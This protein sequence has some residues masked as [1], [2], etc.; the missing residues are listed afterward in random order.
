MSN[1]AKLLSR[2]GALVQQGDLVSARTQLEKAARDHKGS[3]EPWISLAAVHGMGGNY[4][5]ALRCARKAVK[6]A[7]GSL[8]GW[9]NLANAAQSCGEF[10]Q[11]A[12]AF[13][14]AR[15][16][17]GCPPDITLNLGLALAELE[18]WGKAEEALHAYCSRYPG[19]REATLTRGKALA[20]QGEFQAAITI[21]GTYSS[22]HPEDIPALTQLGLLQLQSGQVEDARRNCGQAMESAPDNTDTL[23]LKAALLK[24]EGRYEEARETY[25]QLLRIQQPTPGPQLYILASQACR[26]AGDTD[27]AIAYTRTALELNPHNIPALTTLS[28][29]MLRTD[30]AEARTL[31]EKAIAIAPDDPT[32][33]VQKG[34]V[35]EVEGDKQGAWESVRA[36]IEASSIDSD[37][38]ADAAA[39]AAEVAPVIGN[40]EEVIELLERIVHRD[41]IP[42][43]DQRILRFTLSRVCD[44][45]KQYDR[46]FEHAI[47]ANRLKNAWFDHNAYRVEIDRLKAVYSKTSVNSLPRSSIHSGLPVF[48]VGMPRSGT[49]LLEQI[50]SCHSQVHARGETTDIGNL[51]KK[52]PYYP[53]GVRNLSQKK[54][55]TLAGE[56]LQHLREI[57]PSASRVT[58]KMPGNYRYIGIISQV[59]PGAR[60][61]NC[62][63]DPRSI[64]LSNFMIEFGRGLT[65]AYDLEHLA[66]VCQDY[67]DLMQHWKAVLPMPILDVRY[68]EL[69]IDPRTWVNKVL[70]FC[71]LEW[72]D[73][74]LDFHKSK[75]QVVTASYDQVRQPLYSS[76]VARWKHYERHLEPVSRI[77]GLNDDSYP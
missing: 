12:E 68:E 75:R 47:N 51:A 53:D 71:G 26:H 48:I 55:D 70:D 49:S 23:M 17:P 6:L 44:K 9:V 3:A 54:L 61:I 46:A 50:L 63:R 72:E 7:P 40:T 2:S 39:V 77:L 5:E 58:D 16:L 15:S 13:Q 42:V 22:Q 37:A 56:Y 11:S 21:V 73:G 18:E 24:F 33:L 10:A 65:Y 45:A 57:A 25:E 66:H 67:Q 4:P 76:S 34:R 60:I 35:L 27:T 28:T 32:V 20:R 52:V 41:G 30:P 14:H 29:M 31:M 1:L 64:C 43:G 19:H 59:F 62:R 38:I 69:V 36:A 74:C 8:Q